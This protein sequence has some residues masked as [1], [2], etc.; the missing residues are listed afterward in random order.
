MAVSMIQQLFSEET[1]MSSNV[2]GRKKSSY[3]QFY[4]Q[5]GLSFFLELFWTP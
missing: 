1:R 4:L 2:A 3:I 5:K